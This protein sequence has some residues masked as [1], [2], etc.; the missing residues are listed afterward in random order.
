MN[1][2]HIVAELGAFVFISNF[3]SKVYFR[4]F[5]YMAKTYFQRKVSVLFQ[6]DVWKWQ[7]LS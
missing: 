5:S 7:F 3:G 1:L 2:N 4:F 6:H